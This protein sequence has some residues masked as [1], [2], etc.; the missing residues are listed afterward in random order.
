MGKFLLFGVTRMEFHSCYNN[1]PSPWQLW[2]LQKEALCQSGCLSPCRHK[3][4]KGGVT[5]PWVVATGSS[6]TLI[7]MGSMKSPH[8][9]SSLGGFW[10]S[11]WGSLKLVA[12]AHV[13]FLFIH[14]PIRI[15]HC[16]HKSSVS[17][18]WFCLHNQMIAKQYRQFSV[19]VWFWFL[20]FFSHTWIRSLHF[21]NWA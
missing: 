9:L 18:E 3:G 12:S 15:I 5:P 10:F 17:Q 8:R 11:G 2:A 21:W 16:C 20:S 1:K 6:G 7:R 4:S 13:F 14:S 19:N